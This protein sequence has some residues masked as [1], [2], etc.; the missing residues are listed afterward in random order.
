MDKSSG[1]FSS[2]SE[3]I[4]YRQTF[5]R[6]WSRFIHDNFDD[7]E[8]VAFVFRVDN[9]TARNWWEGTNSPSGFAVAFAFERYHGAADV[10]CG[11]NA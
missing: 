2:K 3:A 10:L 9:K 11:R 6:R 7:P 8:H 4:S 1:T 5:A